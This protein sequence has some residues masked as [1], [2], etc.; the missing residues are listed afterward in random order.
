[1][2]KSLVYRSIIVAVLLL[3]VTWLIMLRYEIVYNISP[4]VAG[5][6]FLLDKYG[7]IKRGAYIVFRL[8]ED[9]YYPASKIL[10][11]VDGIEGDKV[12]IEGEA[13]VIPDSQFFV[14]GTHRRSYDSRYFGLVHQDNIIG[15]ATRI[16]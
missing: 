4:S 16:Y 2:N 10:K 9:P 6:W 13:C 12:N 11:I 15:V 3:L 7:N 8:P 14:Y 1:M 5:K